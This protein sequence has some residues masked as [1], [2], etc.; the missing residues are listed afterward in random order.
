MGF[1]HNNQ[2]PHNHFHKDWQRRVKTWFDQPGRK[3]R[4]REAR[5]AKAAKIAPRPVD[6]LVRPAVRGQ[7]VR[8]NGK[9]R[10]GRGFTIEEIKAA[11]LRPIECRSIG[12]SV[13]HRRKNRSEEGLALNVERIKAY[14]ARLVVVGGK[15]KGVKVGLFEFGGGWGSGRGD[16]KVG[17]G[18]GEWRGYRSTSRRRFGNVARAEGGS[19]FGGDLI[20]TRERDRA[21]RMSL[22]TPNGVHSDALEPPSILPSSLRTPTHNSPFNAPQPASLTV[23]QLATPLLPITNSTAQTEAPRAVVADTLPAFFR[24][25]KGWSDA[26]LA[27]KREKAAR[28]RAV[29]AENKK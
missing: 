11:G 1:R 13:D 6:G 28:E 17:G 10:A 4:R 26:R 15:K 18:V 5:V 7:T 19:P 25:R 12:I 29:E 22:R 16:G 14:R 8:Y 20:L 21:I 23:P 3:K 24:L 9:L 27:G 2:L